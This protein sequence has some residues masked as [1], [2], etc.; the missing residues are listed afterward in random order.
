MAVQV[1]GG[2][3][4]VDRCRNL[5]GRRNCSGLNDTLQRFTPRKCYTQMSR[6]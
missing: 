1:S 6:A 5:R 3:E 4:A 2:R